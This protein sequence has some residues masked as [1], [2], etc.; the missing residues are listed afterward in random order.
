MG[1]SSDFEKFFEFLKQANAL[2]FAM[3]YSEVK[4]MPKDSA[5]SHSWRLA[6]MASLL[7]EGK[8]LDSM[9]AVKIALVHD[10]AE[11][12][13]GDIDVRRIWNGE[14]SKEHKN[15]MEKEAVEKICKTAP[16]NIGKEILALWSEYEKASSREA[17]FVK[18]LDK[19]ETLSH[20]LEQG[21]EYFDVPAEI[22]IYADETV[23][24]FKELEPMLRELKIR[25][26]EEFEKGN[27]EW[28]KE[29]DYPSG[30]Q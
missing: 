15:K 17:R 24:N 25:M 16:A 7:S 27:I 11:S 19:I 6:L 8:N 12:I 22:A 18:A 14:I 4:N 20:L 1:S 13:T 30:L 2:K 5:A 10:I 26:K 23:K 29:F 3:R 9:R 28:K 21:R